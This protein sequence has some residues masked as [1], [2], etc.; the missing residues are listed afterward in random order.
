MA[1]SGKSL[2]AVALAS[3]LLPITSF[4][5]EFPST[6]WA[7]ATPNQAGLNES[8]LAQARD[9]ALAGGGSGMIVHRGKLVMSWGDRKQRYDLKSST[10]SFGAAALALAIGDGKVRLTDPATKHHPAFAVPPASNTN[11]DWAAKITLL[12]LASQTAGFDKP[13]G[14]VPLLYEPG[15]EWAYSD[16]GPN[17]LAECLTLACQRDLSDLLS[18]RIFR[19]IGIQPNDLTWRKNQY[20]PDLIA[21]LKR[22]EFGA[23]IS[24]NVDAMARFGLLWLRGGLWENT[25]ILPREVVLMAGIPASTMASLPVRR[26]DEY[27]RASRHYGLLWWSNADG[28]IE[29]L[30][31]DTFWSWG[32]FDSLIV[33]MP[34]LDIVVTRAGQSWKRTP[35]AGHYDV[36]K[37]FLVPIAQSISDQP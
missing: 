1:T 33:V 16:S 34:S 30:P 20:R 37:P 27:G 17:W 21:D 23:G 5:S 35:G 12:H 31:T 3:L 10:K 19:P 9:Y 11:H 28:T 26:P 25:R 14:Y 6:D 4:S 24:A 8:R 2:I 22:R 32:L 15:T 13:G 36:L 18:D 7:I 29:N